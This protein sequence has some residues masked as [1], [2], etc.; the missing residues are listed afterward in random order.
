MLKYLTFSVLLSLFGI[1]D[2]KIYVKNY[3]QNKNLKEE[4]WIL[5]AKKSDYWFYYFGNGNKKEEGHYKNN[6]KTDWWIY[7]DEKQLITE[8]CQFKNDKRDGISVIFANGKIIKAVRYLNGKKNKTWKNYEEF[9][10]DNAFS[11]LIK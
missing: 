7:Y 1:S 11:Y 2:S 3:H 10:R 8:K 6:Q 4:G 9:R 5:N